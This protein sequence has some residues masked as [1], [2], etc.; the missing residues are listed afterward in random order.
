MADTAQNQ[1]AGRAGETGGPASTI[2]VVRTSHVV[3]HYH[4]LAHFDLGREPASVFNPV[5]VGRAAARRPRTAAPLSKQY[6]RFHSAY[7]SAT[8]RQVVGAL[9]LAAKSAAE[10]AQILDSLEAGEAPSSIP[11]PLRRFLAPLADAS[12]RRLIRLLRELVADEG[13]AFWDAVWLSGVS[14]CGDEGQGLDS[15]LREHVLPFASRLYGDLPQSVIVFPAEAVGARWWSL[16]PDVGEH[17]VVVSP[18]LRTAFFQVLLALIKVRTDRLIRPFLPEDARL[19]PDHPLGM[20][21]RS[22]A[23]MTV[24]H[25]LIQRYRPDRIAEFRA[26]ALRQFENTQRLPSAAIEA[27]QPM[28][29]IP[30]DAIPAITALL[31]GTGGGS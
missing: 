22:D 23:A 9:P 18:V 2:E 17:R 19:R 15:Y 5:Y 27:L 12:G 31:S 16:V 10:Y 24:A 8:G 7:R 4:L 21:M 28:A 26:W 29:L 3:A 30:E 13:A 6:G 25:H 11:M 20:Q 14:V 1:P